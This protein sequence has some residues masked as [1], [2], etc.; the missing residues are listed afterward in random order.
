[1][2]IT[3]DQLNN[4]QAKGL[5]RS[6]PH[7][8]LPL[9]TWNYT[10]KCQYDSAW[11]ELTVQCRGL[12]T[13]TTGNVIARPFSKIFNYEEVKPESLPDTDFVAYQKMD[14]SL[15]ILY[16]CLGKPYIATRGSFDSEQVRFATDLLH[17][18]YAHVVPCL[19]PECTYL[20][21]IIYPENR[22]V[23]DY[24]DVRDIFL[25][26]IIETATGKE[27][28]GEYDARQSP[29]T[30]FPYPT[31]V[32]SVFRLASSDTDL[33][34]KIVKLNDAREIIEAILQAN[35][36][37][38]EGFVIRYANG[39]RVKV[40]F[41]DY[42][43]IH[44]FITDCSATSVWEVLSKGLPFYPFLERLPDE[45]F[46]FV[47][48]TVVLLKQKYAKIEA[49]CQWVVK[50]IGENTTPKDAAIYINTYPNSAVSFAMWHQKPYTHLIW[51]AIK[52]PHQKPTRV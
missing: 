50:S 16:W 30:A 43:D 25:L 45:T 4:L 21:E 39:Y 14:G 22:I 15:G 20:F 10:P 31:R 49:D 51:K 2:N 46:E 29:D 8:T 47:K 12:I 36:E 7:P 44:R 34:G 33:H 38:A 18:K 41:Q 35:T 11:D 27:L 19:R 52:P 9:L 28:V 13:D 26:G 5:V 37:N 3:I 1:M 17:T 32:P 40:K 23:V 48:D 6:T 24:G 42:K